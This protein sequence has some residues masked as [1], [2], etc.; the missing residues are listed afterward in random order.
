MRL[1]LVAAVEIPMHCLHRPPAWS[2]N[3]VLEAI[4]NVSRLQRA[5]ELKVLAQLVEAGDHNLQ[6]A[7]AAK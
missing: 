2:R 7:A 6:P 4:L 3:R 5:A 1:T